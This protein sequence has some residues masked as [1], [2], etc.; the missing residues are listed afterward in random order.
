MKRHLQQVAATWSMLFL[1]MIACVALGFAWVQHRNNQPIGHPM[2]AALPHDLWLS[3]FEHEDVIRWHLEGAEASTAMEHATHGHQALK[4]TFR[5]G[6]QAP[7]II[8]ND[9]TVKDAA[10]RHDW[11]RYDTLSF[12]IYNPGSGSERLLLQLRNGVGSLYKQEFVVPAESARHAVVNLRDAVSY[13]SL[14]DIDE[15]RLFQPEPTQDAVLY[16]DAFHLQ[17]ADVAAPADQPQAPITEI[18]P[19]PAATPIVPGADWQMAWATGLTK[20]LRDPSMFRGMREG[21]IRVALARGEYESAQLALIGGAQPARVAVAIGSLAHQSGATIPANAIEI[22][23][24]EYLNEWPDALSQATVIEVPAGQVQ[25]VWITAGAPDSLPPG[26]YQGTVTVTDEAGRAESMGLEITVWDFTL[27]RTGHL[28]TAFDQSGERDQANL[29]Q[30]RISPVWG[31][32]PTAEQFSAEIHRALDH[33]LTAFG[34]GVLGGSHDNNWPEDAATL[35]Q[36]MPWYRQAALQLSL[37]SLLNQAYVYTYNEPQPGD[38]HVAAVMAAIHREAPG[39]RNLLVLEHAP[40]PIEHAAWLRD[41][42]ILCLR[43]SALDPAQMDRLKA[44]GKEIWFYASTPDRP[45]PSM[46]IDE[47]AMAHRIL[48]WMAWKYGMTGLLDVSDRP[49]PSIRLDNMRDGLEDYEYLVLLRQLMRAAQK[50]PPVNQTL[51]QQAN[52]LVAVDPVLVTS[53]RAYAK[54]PA[55][56]DEQRRLM[57]RTIEQLQQELR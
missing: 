5:P 50:R 43:I 41:A 2:F 57:A 46:Q 34:V 4:V 30:H 13:M 39:L 49:I 52:R 14:S 44:A 8:L 7:A 22:R 26:L 38:A 16:F 28:K 10:P 21:P 35:A 56:L 51:V 6:S 25:P 42:D 17:T 32:D 53:L 55:V 9:F 37:M 27:P 54:D 31:V 1:A 36:V 19:E 18:A 40:D 12:D 23:R 45:Y 48:P 20:L 29:L 24:V 15:L 3:D 33:G 47:P 11:R